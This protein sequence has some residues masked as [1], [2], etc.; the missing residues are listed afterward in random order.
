MGVRMHDWAVRSKTWDPTSLSWNL[1]I[2]FLEHLEKNF[3]NEHS[4]IH[5]IPDYDSKITYNDF[6][7]RMQATQN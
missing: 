4:E 5:G 1:H 6:V 3:R 2:I 7:N